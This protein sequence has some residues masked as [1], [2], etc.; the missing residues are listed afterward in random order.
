MPR[1]CNDWPLLI[2]SFRDD[3][4]MIGTPWDPRKRLDHPSLEGLRAA[5]IPTAEKD[6]GDHGETMRFL[7]HDLFRMVGAGEDGIAV[8]APEGLARAEALMRREG[9]HG[10][11]CCHLRGHVNAPPRSGFREVPGRHR[12]RTTHRPSRSHERSGT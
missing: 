5:L 11:S 1:N 4:H 6:R 7:E 3:L 2:A 12:A 8:N 9:L 10:T